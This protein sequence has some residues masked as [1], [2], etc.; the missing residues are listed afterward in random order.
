MNDSVHTARMQATSNMPANLVWT[1][2]GITLT[3]KPCGKIL[4]IPAA[5]TIPRTI[6]HKR[7]KLMQYN[8]HLFS[9]E[10]S[11][12]TNHD[13]VDFLRERRPT[14]KS[15]ILFCPPPSSRAHRKRHTHTHTH[16]RE[17]EWV[18][19]CLQTEQSFLSFAH[20]K[21]DS[22]LKICQKTSCKSCWMKYDFYGS[23]IQNKKLHSSSDRAGLI[24][25]WEWN[26]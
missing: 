1:V 10:L 15:S 7:A 8:L 18:K 25:I 23:K 19:M 26:R 22:D 2:S 20:F 16:Q 21:S 4:S 13:A 11:S 12:W 6:A 17:R 3:G 9:P 5:E 14:H 24:I